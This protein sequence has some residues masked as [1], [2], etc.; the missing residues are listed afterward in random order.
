[1]GNGIST[2]DLGCGVLGF[3]RVEYYVVVEAVQMPYNQ[4]EGALIKS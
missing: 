1:M 2:K 3:L 4:R